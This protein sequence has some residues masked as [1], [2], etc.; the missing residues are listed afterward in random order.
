VDIKAVRKGLQA[1]AAVI[2]DLQG[3]SYGQGALSI[4]AFFVADLELDFGSALEVGMDVATFNCRA[5]V[6]KVDELGG[7][8]LLDELM[9]RTGDMS[10]KAALE[11]DRTLG[12]ACVELFV[13]KVVGP[14][15]FRQDLT[16]YLGAQWAVQVTGRGE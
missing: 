5:L 4:P 2:P 7:Q 13:S 10:V 16:D 8:E 12:G 14:R 9:S 1:A 3:Y 11:A 6:S 15:V